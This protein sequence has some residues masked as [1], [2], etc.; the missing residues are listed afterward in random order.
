MYNTG[1]RRNQNSGLSF[2]CFSPPVMLA[3]FFIELGL[4][5]YSVIR[6]KFNTLTRLVG[7]LLFFLALFQLAEYNV[8]G[9]LGTSAAAWSRIGFVAITILPP[10]GI[11]LLHAIA[12]KPWNNVVGA[13]YGMAAAWIAVFAFSE[14]AFSGHVC[15]GNYVIFQIKPG[16]GGLYF[17]YYYFWLFVGAYLC[18]KFAKAMKKDGQESL[19]LLALGYATLLIPTTLANMTKPETVQG[20]PSIM[21]GFAIILAGIAALGILPR[22]GKLRERT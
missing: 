4:L 6:Y 13:A 12:K 16:L 8:C 15:A 3:T 1:M 17:L 7:A 14:R 5:V 22:S 19:L 9:G 11:H 18:V 20:I 21:C 2:Y 10:I